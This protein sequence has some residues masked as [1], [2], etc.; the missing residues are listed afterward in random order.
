MTSSRHTNIGTSPGRA[1]IFHNRLS[2]FT[3]VVPTYAETDCFNSHP[4]LTRRL[5][6]DFTTHESSFSPSRCIAAFPSAVLEAVVGGSLSLQGVTTT[7]PLHP[8]VRP[9]SAGLATATKKVMGSHRT[10]GLRW[11]SISRL[12]RKEKEM[13]R[14]ISE[15]RASHGVQ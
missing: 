12:S 7:P 14:T 4:D 13:H 9:P 15:R 10:I 3:G 1:P 8:K 2:V 6:A 11:S 5:G